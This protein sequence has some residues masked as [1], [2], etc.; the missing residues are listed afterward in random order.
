MVPFEP[1][2]NLG[3]KSE[4]LGP[5]HGEVRPM[6]MKARLDQEFLLTGRGASRDAPAWI[7]DQVPDVTTQNEGV[8]VRQGPLG[9]EINID[10]K[11]ESVRLLLNNIKFTCSRGQIHDVCTPKSIQ[12]R[13]RDVDLAAIHENVGRAFALFEIPFRNQ[14]M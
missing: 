6:D 7:T 4:G 8:L 12:I 5:I 2:E 9:L 3:P 10:E 13:V 11:L 14:H 1:E